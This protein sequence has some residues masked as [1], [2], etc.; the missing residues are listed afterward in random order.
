MKHMVK[1]MGGEYGMYYHKK[2]V[3]AIEAR[4]QKRQEII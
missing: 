2:I 4:M 1:K 3:D